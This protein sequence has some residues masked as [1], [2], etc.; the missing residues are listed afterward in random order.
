MF[1]PLFSKIPRP[2]LKPYILSHLYSPHQWEEEL[3]QHPD[4]KL[5]S[6][7]LSGLTNRFL[8]RHKH[9]GCFRVST[10]KNMISVVQTSTPS[11]AEKE[12]GRNARPFRE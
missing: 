6:Y 2:P 11:T 10:R 4:Q 3:W 12:A 1:R 7:V 5:V 9:E 8:I